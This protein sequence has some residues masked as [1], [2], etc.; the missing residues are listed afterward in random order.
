M[1]LNLFGKYL[2]GSGPLV[3]G[4]APLDP[5]PAPIIDRVVLASAPSGHHPPHRLHRTSLPLSL[6]TC[7]D[8]RGEVPLF[9]LSVHTITFLALTIASALL[10]YTH[11]ALTIC[12]WHQPLSATVRTRPCFTEL[13]RRPTVVLDPSTRAG[14]HP[15]NLKPSVSLYFFH[16]QW[17]Y[18]DVHLRSSSELAVPVRSSATSPSTSAATRAPA[19]TSPL[20]PRRRAPPAKAHRHEQH[21]SVSFHPSKPPRPNPHV[22]PVLVEPCPTGRRPVEFGRENASDAMG[23]A[24]PLLWQLGQNALGVGPP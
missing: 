10:S 17:F 23:A 4:T 22:V 20:T 1:D 24:D 16:H 18:N 11:T 3:S 12:H 6:S 7:G 15:F 19:S 5:S 21:T 13:R 14:N 8:R 9:I 2:N